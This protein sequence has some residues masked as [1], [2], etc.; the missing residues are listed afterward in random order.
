MY[1]VDQKARQTENESGSERDSEPERNPN[2]RKKQ[3]EL[4]EE[5]HQDV[6]HDEGNEIEA[7]DGDSQAGSDVS[8]AFSIHQ[9]S[10]NF[11]KI[12]Q[13]QN[14][15]L[16]LGNGGQ[17][18]VG[19]ADQLSKAPDGSLVVNSKGHRGASRVALQAMKTLPVAHPIV[20]SNEFPEPECA[21]GLSRYG[22]SL[23]PISTLITKGTKTQH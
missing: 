2:E 22:V 3:N 12:P 7:D 17:S 18:M 6:E 15:V 4:D 13:G 14:N 19:T 5:D 11:S 23:R 20:D 8:D 16:F 9:F 1:T 10:I 21:C